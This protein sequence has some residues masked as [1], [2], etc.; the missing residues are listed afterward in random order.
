MAAP[1]TDIAFSES[2]T[3]GYRAF[4]NKIWNAARFMFMNVDQI[5]SKAPNGSGPP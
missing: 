1:G 5:R 2:R 4:A 3:D